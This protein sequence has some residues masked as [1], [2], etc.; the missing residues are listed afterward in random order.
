MFVKNSSKKV[1]GFGKT[2]IL[3]G[4]SGE[5]PEGFDESHPTVNF[6]FAKGWLEKAGRE[7]AT[8]DAPAESTPADAD[9]EIK[10]LARMNLEPLREKAAELGLEWSESDTRAK[11]VALITEKLISN[12]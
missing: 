5:L 7:N 2:V 8:A 10:Q 6:Y 3:P 1:M 11:L 12:G 9:A 4:E